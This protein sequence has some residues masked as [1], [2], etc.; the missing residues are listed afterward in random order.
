MGYYPSYELDIHEPTNFEYSPL[1]R[2]ASNG[3]YE[4]V[5]Y[6]ISKGANANT[7]DYRGNTP[8]HHALFGIDPVNGNVLKLTTPSHLSKSHIET[9]K[10]LASICHNPHTPNNGGKTPE[11]YATTI[12]NGK[13]ILP[14]ITGKKIMKELR[15]TV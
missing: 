3:H 2:A 4:I 15:Y 14:Y 9:I 1:H 13:E 11:Y 10:F 7:P 12:K 6:L 8:I 5:K